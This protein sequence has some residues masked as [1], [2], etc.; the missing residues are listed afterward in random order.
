MNNLENSKQL[1]FQLINIMAQLR[2]P[3]GCP[4]D[5]HQDHASLLPYLFS[6]AK[7]VRDA[8]KK[9]DW[10]NLKEELGD[11]MLQIV[12]HSRIAQEKRIFDICDVLKGINSKLKRRHP[13]VFGGR[14]LRTPDQV[15][16]QW[17]EIKRQEKLKRA[18]K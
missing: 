17:E 4:W 15:D 11:L 16:K 3:G 5:K 2:G 6:E 12:F 14:K 18:R 1:F 13:H 7:E 9:K 10:A 8:V